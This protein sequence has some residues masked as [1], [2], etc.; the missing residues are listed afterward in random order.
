MEK[1]RKIIDIVFKTISKL[2]DLEYM[3][4]V[5][6]SAMFVALYVYLY[7][8]GYLSVNHEFKYSNNMIDF[9]LLNGVDVVR[10]RGVCRS[11]SSM[12]TDCRSYC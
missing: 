6:E 11:I 1:S 9:P 12:F 7:R 4:R 8:S 5:Y 10:G 2:S 3:K